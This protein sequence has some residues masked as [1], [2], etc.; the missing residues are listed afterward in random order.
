[1]KKYFTL[2]LLFGAVAFSWGKGKVPGFQGK[3]FL[4]KYDLG[5]M[6]PT[7]V[8][9]TG[10]L[11]M[12]YHN[13][14]ADYVIARAWTIGVKYGF[15]T[16]KSHTDRKGFYGQIEQY[17][18]LGDNVNIKDYKGRYTQHTVSVLAKKFDIKKGYIAPVGRYV[19]LGVYYQYAT[20]QLFELDGFYDYQTGYSEVNVNSYKTT[21]H[22]MGFTIGTGRNFIIARRIIVDIGFCLNVTP[23]AMVML[24]GSPVQQAEWRNIMLRNLFQINVG[25]GSLIF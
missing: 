21:A 24:N 23:F 12:L 17:Y 9:R 13:V 19:I 15:M 25:L 6:H 22:F 16:Y 20:D 7:L 1:M 8:G 14:S 10:V 11:P 3:K 5:I 2:L 18:G 4:M